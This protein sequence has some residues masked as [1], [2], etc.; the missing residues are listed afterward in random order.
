M[1]PGFIGIALGLA[2]GVTAVLV[3]QRCTVQPPAARRATAADGRA[4]LLACGA[5]GSALALA[6]DRIAAPVHTYLTSE[7]S[8]AL[9]AARGQVANLIDA[10]LHA[11]N[12]ALEV[13][14]TLGSAFDDPRL[15]NVPPYIRQLQI[16]H[17]RLAELI[18]ALQSPTASD[19]P[20]KLA[21]LDDAMHAPSTK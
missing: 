16:A 12:L 1:K 4:E 10:R 3:S 17:V 14:R 7:P 21:A 8:K 18:T 2:V 19:A 5:G 9:D 15:P 20:Q 13:K 6:Y 11:C